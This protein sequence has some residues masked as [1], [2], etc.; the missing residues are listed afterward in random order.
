LGG[1][2][3]SQAS[4]QEEVDVHYVRGLGTFAQFSHVWKNHH[5]LV[6]TKMKVFSSFIVTHFIYGSKTWLLMQA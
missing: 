1:I 3:N 2:V 5:L 4:L 6:Q